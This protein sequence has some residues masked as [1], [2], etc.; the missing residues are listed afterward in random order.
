MLAT[1]GP[2][3]SFRVGYCLSVTGTDLP[4]SAAVPAE[5]GFVPAGA[6]SGPAE[7]AIDRAEFPAARAGVVAD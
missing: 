2:G 5:A 6:G 4:V 1:L 3:G 7:C